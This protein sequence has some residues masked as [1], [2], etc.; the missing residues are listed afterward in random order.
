MSGFLQSASA[1]GSGVRFDELM[2]PGDDR[3]PR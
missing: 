1:G 3:E 2:K